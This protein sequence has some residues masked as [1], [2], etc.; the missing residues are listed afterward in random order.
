MCHKV[1]KAFPCKQVVV[2]IDD[3]LIMSRSFEDHQSLV[4]SVLRTFKQYGIKINPGKCNW[5]MESVPFLKHL[6]GHDGLKKAPA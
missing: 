3:I 2:Y 5:F 4:D 1:L 6:I